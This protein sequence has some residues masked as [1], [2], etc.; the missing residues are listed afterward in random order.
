VGGLPAL[1]FPAGSFELALCSHLLFLY[2][3]LLD[4]EFHVRALTELLRVAREVRL[5]PLLS[6]DLSRSRHL[7]A[8][9]AHCT[10]LG[11]TVS[12][13]TVGY[14]LQRGGNEALIVRNPAD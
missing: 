12:I 3:D 11:C 9:V 5:F 1:P 13:E 6:L 4:L 10:R 7:E 14:E 8:V 2:S